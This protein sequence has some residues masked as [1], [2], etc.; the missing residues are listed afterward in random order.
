MVAAPQGW[1]TVELIE[2]AIRSASNPRAG[3]L[4]VRLAY[5]VAAGSGSI[6]SSSVSVAAEVAALT[7]DR[8]LAAADLRDLLRDAET[9]A[10]T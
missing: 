10:R 1:L 2:R 7:R 8:E 4:A 3:E 5:M 9:A 6:A